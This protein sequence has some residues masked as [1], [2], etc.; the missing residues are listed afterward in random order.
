MK[1]RIAHRTLLNFSLVRFGVRTYVSSAKNLNDVD[2]EVASILQREEARQRNGLELIASEN[3]TSKAVM[4]ALGSCLTNKYSE[5]Y[6]N[7]RY[8]GGNQ[9]IDENELL[10]QQRA[11]KLFQLDPQAWGVNV[12]PYSGS[13][14]NFAAY[15]ALLQ[16]H[17]R[18]MGL[19][20]PHGGHLTHGYMSDKRRISATSIFFESMPYRLD[21]QT[22]YIDY[23][24]LAKNAKLFRPKLII[25][26]ASAYP[27]NIDY[28][29]MR[30]ICDDVGALLLSDMAHTS[31]LVAAGQ[32]SNPFEYSDVVTSTTHKT[33]RG[34]RSGIIFFK[35]GVKS[36]NKKTGVTTSYDYEDRINFAVFPSLQGGPHN[37]VIAALNVAL[38]EAMTDEFN[39]YQKQVKINSAHLGDMM[40][41]Y[42]Y[43]LVSGGTDNHLILVDLK[44]QGLDGARAEAVLELCDI[45]VNKNTVPGDTKPLVPGGLR[46]GT[47]ALTTRGFKEKDFEKVAEYLH[48]GIQLTQKINAEEGN[49]KSLKT[50]K[51]A[52]TH[53]RKDISDLATEVQKFASGFPMPF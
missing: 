7:A 30:T 9:I 17:D 39:E 15:T 36:V 53:D 38:K 1:T 12:Q 18:L 35:K 47:P 2:P 44:P 50:F 27:R 52:L 11:L 14:A 16:P 25:A 45:T 20:L 48:K 41:N 37:N 34:P 51:T 43:S 19:D 49:S 28:G 33:L 40:K 10:C 46:I 8:Y 23:D 6:P 24:Q 42:G 4:Q 29:R 31:G 13:P 22:G 5:G 26:G 32:A 21:E 3:F